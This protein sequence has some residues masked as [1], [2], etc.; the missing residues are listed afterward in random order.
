MTHSIKTNK[1]DTLEANVCKAFSSGGQLIG[2]E[3][4]NWSEDKRHLI[5]LSAFLLGKTAATQKC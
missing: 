3:E 2:Q 4:A 5:L 1:K